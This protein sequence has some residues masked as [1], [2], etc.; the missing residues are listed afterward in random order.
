[1]LGSAARQPRFRE[2]AI[3]FFKG[4]RAGLSERRSGL[5]GFR[6][7]LGGGLLMTVLTIAL[8]P[9]TDVRGCSNYGG[10]GNGTA[11]SDGIW[12]LIYPLLLLGWL[13]AVIVEQLLPVTWDGRKASLII[14]R[15]FLA[16]A[17]VAVISCGM[18]LKL[19]VLCH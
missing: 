11:F 19:L 13:V 4:E 3:F 10:N 6:A 2:P 9:A 5:A 15:A 1:M 16:V 14:V 17:M 18:E 12:D 8:Q 7:A